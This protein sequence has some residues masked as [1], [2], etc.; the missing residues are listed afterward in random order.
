MTTKMLRIGTRASPLALAQSEEVRLRL[1]DAHPGLKQ[2]QIE[3]V[4]MTTSGDKVQDKLLGEIGG[5]GLFT[6]EIE[7]ALLAGEVD[8][9]VHSMKDM[10]TELPEGLEISCLLE[11]EDPFDAFI[12]A[13]G[14]SLDDLPDG[15]RI[16]TA[17]LRRGAQMKHYRPDFQIVPLRGSVQTRLRKLEAGDCHATLLAVA[18][19]KR[20]HMPSVIT[21]ILT[22]DACL[23]AVAQ[24]AIGIEHR[25]DNTTIRDL[26]A[27]LNHM[28]TQIRVT[29]ERALLAV[30]DGSCRTPIAALATLH[31]EQMVLDGLIAKPDGSILHRGRREGKA[32]LP[33][34]KQLGEELGHYL[35]TLSGPGFL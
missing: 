11:R 13:D 28:P 33:A 4:P 24:G 29:A 12:S 1:L 30:L 5:K 27:P 23:P 7:D 18:G 26:L 21:Q 32:T 14:S 9:A 31:G 20:L 25:T 2:G 8:M 16:G 22:A 35:K 17:S 6:K 15:A 10:P 19:L 3:L 34:A